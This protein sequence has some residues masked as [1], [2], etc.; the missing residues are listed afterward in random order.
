MCGFVAI[1]GKCH[2][3]ELAHMS[4]AVAR[5]GPDDQGDYDDGTFSAIH[6]RLSIIGPDMR[7]RQ[8]MTVDDVTVVFNGCIYNYRELRK[9][10]EDDGI[11]F[12]SD[13]DTEVLPH[14]YRR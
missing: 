11:T 3:G 2:A 13:T 10:L 14:L 12:A 4:A 5:R 8:P 7:G 9:Q 6:H 1:L